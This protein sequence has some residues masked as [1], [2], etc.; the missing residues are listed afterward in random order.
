MQTAIKLKIDKLSFYRDHLKIIDSVSY[1]FV[2]AQTTLLTGPSGC[3]KT[4]FLRLLAGLETPDSGEISANGILWSSSQ[5]VL[6]PWQRGL[7]MLFQGDA[8]WP[9]Q[10]ISQQISWVK[11][12]SQKTSIN[13]NLDEIIENLGIKDLLNRYPTGLSGG[14]ARRCQLARILAGS[15]SVILLDE[16]LS[17]QD[18]DTAAR[19]AQLLGKLLKAAQITTIIVSHEIELFSDFTW[20]TLSLPGLNAQKHA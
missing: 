10:T 5:N 14:E 12:R 2:A 7:D 16:P 13:C 1:E 20:P 19:T 3:G 17:G 9:N 4:T 6:P 18:T 15:P 8:L 11:N